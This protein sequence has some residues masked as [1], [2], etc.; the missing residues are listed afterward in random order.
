V[1]TSGDPEVRLLVAPAYQL[2][3]LWLSNDDT[4]V[5]QVVVVDAPSD[6]GDLKPDVWHNA[7]AFLEVLYQQVPALGVL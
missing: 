6:Y 3:A 4:S 2:H 7:P 5:D 1:L